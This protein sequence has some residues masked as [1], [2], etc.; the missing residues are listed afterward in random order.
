[1]SDWLEKLLVHL[2]FEDLIIRY[3]QLYLLGSSDDM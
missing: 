3:S 1:M 2:N